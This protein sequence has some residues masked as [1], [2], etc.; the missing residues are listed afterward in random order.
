MRTAISLCWDSTDVLL[1]QW[2]KTQR[3][4][5]CF[6]YCVFVSDFFSLAFILPFHWG[7][8][9]PQAYYEGKSIRETD[10]FCSQFSVRSEYLSLSNN[11]TPSSPCKLLERKDSLL[12]SR[13]SAGEAGSCSDASNQ[14]AR[15]NILARSLPFLLQGLQ[16]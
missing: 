9:F 2:L 6:F 3:Q 16:R 12:A 13:K 4:I 14:S 1:L 11:W 5:Y 10:K 15:L 8:V 7:F